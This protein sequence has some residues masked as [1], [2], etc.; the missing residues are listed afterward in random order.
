[1]AFLFLRVVCS[2]RKASFSRSCKNTTARQNEQAKTDHPTIKQ[3][4]NA[5]VDKNAVCHGVATLAVVFGSFSL[6]ELV[7]AK[8]SESLSEVCLC[9]ESSQLL[10]PLNMQVETGFSEMKT[11][12]S[13]QQSPFS[14]ETYNGVRLARSFF[15]RSSCE[16]IVLSQ[17][18]SLMSKA[19]ESY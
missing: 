12:E 10:S 8:Q 5:Q 13:L 6:I 1:M 17:F 2:K 19:A 11:A 16:D 7:Q 9:C 3:L 15:S 4:V 14:P 18:S